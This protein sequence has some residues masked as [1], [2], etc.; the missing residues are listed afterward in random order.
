MLVSEEIS[1]HNLDFEQNVYHA[2]VPENRN[3]SKGDSAHW[4]EPLGKKFSFD[5]IQKFMVHPEK[6]YYH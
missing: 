3:F 2:R 1:N 4:E 6:T 5:I